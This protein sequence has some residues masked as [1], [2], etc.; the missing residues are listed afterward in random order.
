M[1]I[2]ISHTIKEPI[3]SQIVN[4]IKEQ[5][6]FGYL[7]ELHMLPSIRKLANEL[8]I[9]VITT[10]RAYEELEKEGFITTIIGKGSFVAA[11]NKE[12]WR[13]AIL[14]TAEEK[15]RE[16]VKTTKSFGVTLE[17]L[18]KILEFIYHH[19]NI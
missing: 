5:I 19:E 14:N 4:Q 15:M 17:D 9:S 2:I 8:N 3:Y 13:E 6:I 7:E 12:K 16:I 11:V 18:E 10:K 1:N